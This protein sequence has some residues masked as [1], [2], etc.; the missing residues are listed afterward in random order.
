MSHN[1]SSSELKRIVEDIQSDLT[2]MRRPSEASLMSYAMA[3]LSPQ[4]KAHKELLQA[5]DHLK[6]SLVEDFIAILKLAGKPDPSL[7]S[8]SS[9]FDHMNRRFAD[10]STL[11]NKEA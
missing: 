5:E 7:Q 2:I 11:E 8:D 10:S 9:Y 1:N 6:L 4:Q 3:L